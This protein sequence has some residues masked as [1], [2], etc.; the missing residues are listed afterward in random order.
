ML[1]NHRADVKMIVGVFHPTLNVCGG[2]EWVGLN[3]I[4]CLKQAGYTVVVMT[5]EKINK[6][7]ITKLFGQP[8]NI[9]KEIIFP[10]EPFRETDLHN[11]YTDGVRTLLLKSKCDVLLDTQSNA[12]LPGV[13]IAY[14][15]YPILGRLIQFQVN[16]LQA[17]FYKPYLVYEQHVAANYKHLLLANSVYTLN[18][19]K[20]ILDAN[21]KLLYPPIPE[22]CYI[23][24]N[25]QISRE[26]LVVSV[27]R[28]ASTKMF[29]VIPSIA[30]LTPE[31]IHF[32]IVGIGEDQQTLDKILNEIK[33]C[34]VEK[35]VEL[36]INASRS[37]LLSILRKAKVYLHTAIGEHFGVSIAEGMASGCIPIVHNSGGPLYFLPG[38]NRY[39]TC[40]EA[41]LK[42]NKAVYGWSVKQSN[43]FVDAAMKFSQ[44]TFRKRFLDAFNSSVAQRDTI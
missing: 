14:I 5:N 17:A 30:K 19:L 16:K 26:N 22:E 8:V 13:D 7:K 40:E 41:A 44:N 21:S 24:K 43:E 20:S 1:L 31:N 34:N 35:R 29:H 9:D 12:V 4:N 11:L 39:D 25:D 33:R 36:V 3:L 23:D 2:A 27:G 10:F 28:I 18:M 32:K 37:N 15:H 6:E 38:F 42:I